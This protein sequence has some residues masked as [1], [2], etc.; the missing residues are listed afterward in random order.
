MSWP[1]PA[2][3][4]VPAHISAGRF[5]LRRRGD[6]CDGCALHESESDSQVLEHLPF[7]AND[8]TVRELRALRDRLK[9]NRMICPSRYV[10]RRAI[11]SWAGLPVIRATQAMRK[12]RLPWWDLKQPPDEILVL[13]A[14][15]RQRTHQFDAALTDLAEVLTS[16][17]RNTQARLTRAAVLQ[18]QGAYDAAREE[19]LALQSL[20]QELV[21]TACLMSV[22]GAA[23]KL[24][25]S[26]EQ[27][28]A[29]LNRQRY[30]QQGVRSWVLTSLRRDGGAGRHG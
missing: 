19:C 3:R 18:V 7:Q 10:W 6:A 29:V 20:T 28:R 26:Y 15:L 24:R 22:N 27:L 1:T 4:C 2:N 21:W 12:P 5:P 13:R 23:G 8:P 11:W 14:A 30:V 17:P 16:N 25:E 9:N